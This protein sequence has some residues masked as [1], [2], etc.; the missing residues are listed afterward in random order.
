MKLLTD[1]KLDRR[2]L[3]VVMLTTVAVLLF[4]LG[5][6]VS[7]QNL[8]NERQA[9]EREEAQRLLLTFEAHSTRLFDYAD[10][11][12]RAIRAY[13]TEHGVSNQWGRF[14]REIKAPHA[15]TFSGIVTVIDRDG[16]VVYQSETP[17]DKLKSFG[18]MA[19][20]D[21]YQYF[22]RHPVDSLFIGATRIGKL[23][24]KLQFRLARPLLRD[25]AFVGLVMITLLPEHITDFY[26]SLQLGPNSSIAMLTLEPKLIA[27][28][29]T[30]ASSM[31]DRIVPELGSAIGIDIERESGGTAFG[32]EG[33]FDRIR[34]DVFYKK[35]VDY[36]VLLVIGIAEQDL[37]DAIAS[38]RSSLG[39]L[40][41]AFAA[42]S[43]FVCFLMLRITGQNRRLKEAAVQLQASESRLISAQ[44]IASVGSWTLE[45]GSG[46]LIWS[47]EIFRLF[48]IDSG[49]FS[50]T[51]HAFLE[52]IHPED[53][54]AVNKAY[55]ESLENRSP[56]EITH[57]LLM[58]DGR[59]KWVQERCV[60]EFDAAGKPL[61]SS[62]TVQDI[63]ELKQAEE[64]LLIAA[65]AFESQEG[66]VVT[67]ANS[68][69][70]R[71]NRAFTQT[72]GYSADEVVG[73]TPRLYKSGRHPADFY[74]AMWESILSTGSW[75]GEIWDRR[76]NG[77]EY[78]KWL[79]ISAV[80][81]TQGAVSHYVA[82]HVDITERKK[83]EEMIEG[84]AFFDQLTGL[85]NRFSLHERLA[86]ALG[87]ANRSKQQLALMLIDLDNFKAIN[88]TLG[89][90]IGDKLLVEV[91]GRL[92]DSV[93]QSDLVT[94]LGGDEFVIVLSDIDSPTDA[95]H[96]ADKIISTISA[97]YRIDGQDL[98]TSPSIGICLYPDDATESQELIKKA[99][100]AMYHAKAQ[101]R[102]G[103]QFFTEDMQVAAVKRLAIESELRFAI[104]QRQFV[105]HYQPQLDLASGRLVGVEALIRWQHPVRGLV[106]PLEFI[107]IAEE[108]GLIVPI[109]DWVLHEACAQLA[110]WRRNGLTHLRMS[111]NLAATQFADR[112]LPA[113]IQE[114]M[115]TTGLPAGVLDLEVTESMTMKS[116]ADTT[117]LMNTLTK[118][119][120]S[121]SIDDFGTGYSSLAYLKLFPIS[122]LKID[123]SFVK[124]IETDHNDADICDVIVLLAH[125]LELDVVAEGVE[126]EA[127]LKFLL[128]IGCEKIQGYLISK[129]LPAEQ[130]EN[131]VSN[132]TPLTGLATIDLW[133]SNQMSPALPTPS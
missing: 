60:S 105:L 18:T 28:Q 89:H 92:V 114:I 66:I 36:P 68:V 108:T 95:A 49:Q 43:L 130:L 126:T 48:E 131:L 47:D 101:G 7:Y 129:P 117:A 25:G 42:I 113:R 56:Y 132:W 109:G 20:L 40:A 64:Q 87:L 70:L 76:K 19:G 8:R 14:V 5:C 57:R 102:A 98:R 45:V 127:Q 83:A 82:T 97:P 37:D 6:F 9:S 51:Y 53:R 34:R 110:R 2:S 91:A 124:D 4:S 120:L 77:E 11:Y 29:P 3:I 50:A 122:T 118:Q 23:T 54:D 72:S 46:K 79:T 74:R 128:S 103:Y 115:D 35:L 123:R 27:H 125:K 16:W 12:L 10:S 84:L 94:R 21:H 93:R 121:L 38:A 55:T 63:S 32:V 17:L 100:V 30:P 81:N 41:L 75:Q 104:E 119:H 96:V 88:D 78:P 99:D 26:R 80:R 133:P 107:P 52:A 59:I 106:S 85:H 111:V 67:D 86:Q 39:L 15:E 61:V 116:P 13:H 1:R 58:P 24:G 69:I 33:P 62:G 22:N 71:V 31:Y 112:S 65:A 44:R 90:P 73:Q